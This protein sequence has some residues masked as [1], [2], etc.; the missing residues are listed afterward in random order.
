MFSLQWC[1]SRSSGG[2]KG[3]ERLERSHHVGEHLFTHITFLLFLSWPWAGTNQ[4]FLGKAQSQAAHRSWCPASCLQL[5][6]T[7]HCLPSGVW[8]AASDVHKVS[9]EAFYG[10][11]MRAGGNVDCFWEVRCG[12]TGRVDTIAVSSMSAFVGH[13]DKD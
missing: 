1:V 6:N 12:L 3:C 7:G 5:G 4:L 11:V 13:R 9:P 8:A 2:P 10:L